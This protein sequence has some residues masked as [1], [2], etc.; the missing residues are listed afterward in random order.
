MPATMSQQVGT[1]AQR[2]VI[3]SLQA[4]QGAVLA[5]LA[6]QAVTAQQS[7]IINNFRGQIYISDQLDVEDT[8]LYDTFTATAGFTMTT[9]NSKLFANVELGSGKTAAQ[10]NM[11]EN[12]QL[13]A[14]EAF[15]VFGIR[16]GWSEAILRSDLQ[17]FVDS[18][19]YD[20]WLG[21]KSY[22]KANPRHFSSGWGISGFSTRTG[23]SAYTNG[24]SDRTS[25]NTL[26]VKLV[27]ANQQ[28]FF[29][30]FIGSQSQV[31]SLNGTGGIFLNELVGLYARGVQ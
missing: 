22:N 18:W 5:T 6:Q 11:T 8:P 7:F 15:S 16:L 28:S 9:D 4:N 30:Q 21:N 10:T 27:F 1:N 12:R 29:A 24:W 23:E 3:Q 2:A 26:A 25:M 19:A 14:P 17:T 31:F 13:P 20:L